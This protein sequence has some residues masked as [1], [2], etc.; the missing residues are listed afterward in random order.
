MVPH[1]S[2]SVPAVMSTWF[3]MVALV[4]ARL[5]QFGKWVCVEMGDW[6]RVVEEKGNGVL[7][8]LEVFVVGVLSGGDDRGGGRGAAA[9]AATGR[10]Q[11]QQYQYQYQ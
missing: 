6:G 3:T 11:Q 9:A 1:G 10:E 2:V 5:L 7:G 8:V 4:Y